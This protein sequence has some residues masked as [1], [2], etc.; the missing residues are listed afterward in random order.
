M[1]RPATSII[2]TSY[3]YSRYLERCLTS[4]VEQTTREPFEVLIVDDGSTDQS[5]DIAR[6]FVGPMVRLLERPNGGIEKASNA[7]IAA[8]AAD[9][10]V[11]VD[12]D[13]YLLPAY[14]ETMLSRMPSAGTA[15]LYPDYVVVD[16][17]DSV[18]YEEQLPPFDE[19]EIKTRG[20]FLATGTLYQREAIRQVGGYEEATRNSGLEN[21]EL[22]LKLLRAGHTGR[23]VPQPLFAYRRHGLN[24]SAQRRDAI[25]GYGRAL[26]HSLSLG[27]YT[28]NAFHPYKLVLDHE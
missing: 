27:P 5:Q 2:V 1:T 21:Y 12:A 14:L 22:I 28:T 19:A 24:V 26:F 16:E 11:R 4:C 10:I 25:V 6:R 9:L 20:D 18:M 15:F 23:H 7:G 13:D 8:A 17:H 3:N